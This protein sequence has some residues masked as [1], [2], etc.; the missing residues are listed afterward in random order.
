M[1]LLVIAAVIALVGA[2]PQN[3]NHPDHSAR[4]QYRPIATLRDQRQDL[5]DGN[6][7]YE[8]L[9]EN[10]INVGARGTPGFRGQSNINGF[11]SYPLSDGSYAEV[12]Y[13]ADEL[14]YRADSRLIPSHRFRFDRYLHPL[15]F[16]EEQRRLRGLRPLY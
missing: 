10:G 1:H 11:Y 9:T 12:R 5:G 13:V 6:F 8:F 16:A 4:V 2:A 15:R 3:G 7:N 14:G